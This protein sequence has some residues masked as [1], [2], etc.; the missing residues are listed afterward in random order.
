MLPLKSGLLRCPSAQWASSVPISRAR[1]AP[2]FVVVAIV[3][4]A[5]LKIGSPPMPQRQFAS[6]HINCK[7]APAARVSISPRP[8]RL[9][10]LSQLGAI[11]ALK[12]CLLRPRNR[13]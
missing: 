13:R 4:I 6:R 5:A 7:E 12:R 1:L 2:T 11:P 8:R 9:R 3:P 10:G